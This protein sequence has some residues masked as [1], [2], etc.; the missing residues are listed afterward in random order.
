MCQQNCT[1]ACFPFPIHTAP[2]RTTHTPGTTCSPRRGGLRAVHPT[3]AAPWHSSACR[4][5]SRQASGWMPWP[6]PPLLP[7]PPLWRSWPPHPWLQPCRTE[8][9]TVVM[10]GEQPRLH[11]ANTCR[12]MHQHS[13]S[14]DGMAAPSYHR[15]GCNSDCNPVPAC[16]FLSSPLWLYCRSSTLTAMAR[17]MGRGLGRRPTT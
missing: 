14:A 3:A 6:L 2:G 8:R 16:H 11:Q 7:L 12:Q 1:L 13:P 10:G 5:Q 15:R 4:S 9:C 17:V